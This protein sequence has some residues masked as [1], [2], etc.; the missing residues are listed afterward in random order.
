MLGT[1]GDSS[2]EVPGFRTTGVT[3]N[4]SRFKR[5]YNLEINSPDLSV[6]LFPPGIP[7]PWYPHPQRSAASPAVRNMTESSHHLLKSQE[8]SG[9]F[10]D[11]VGAHRH[12]SIK[13]LWVYRG[14]MAVSS[15]WQI[16]GI[17]NKLR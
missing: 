2:R 15:I 1:L 9:K 17:R 14:N 5:L 3:N 7:E 11:W 12:L 6:I 4:Y 8:C 10:S 16:N 13:C